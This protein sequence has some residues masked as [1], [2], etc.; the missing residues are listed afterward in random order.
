MDIA[1]TPKKKTSKYI[2]GAVVGAVLIAG[3]VALGMLPQAAPSVERSSL[4]IDS[5]QRGTMLRAVRAPGTLVPERVHLVSA[6]TAGRVERLPIRPGAAVTRGAALLELSNP[7][8]QL[9]ALD[10]ERQVAAAEAELLNLETS[11]ATERYTQQAN[12]ATAEATAS[13]A[14]RQAALLATLGAKQFANEN[15]ILQANELA[16]EQA[17][18]L[19]AEKGRLSVLDGAR[20]QR[21]ALQ[22]SEVQR[23][24]AIADFQR[25]R[26][27]SMKVSAPEDGVLQ[28][29]PLELGQWVVPGQVLATLAQPGRLKAMLRVPE[30]QARDIVIGQPVDIDTRNGIAKGHVMRVDPSVQNGTVTVEVALDGT[31]PRGARPDLSVDGTIEIERL[32]DVLHVGRP[33]YGQGESTFGIF[34]LDPDGKYAT[35]TQ[36]QF[37]RSSV[38]MIEILKG[39]KAGDRVITSDMSQWDN[40]KRVKLK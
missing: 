15:D 10:A 2:L 13:G 27:A 20:A 11:L 36:V 23:A 37:G 22:K 21:I 26:V 34:K 33:A 40:M 1:R 16:T 29:L 31:L 24:R 35:R 3:T 12:V 32:P 8:V 6:L 38:T 19:V 17:A 30:T 5:V 4:M 25:E 39:L 7:D 9:E 18:R 28:T 14:K